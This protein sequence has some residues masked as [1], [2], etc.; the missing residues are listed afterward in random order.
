M[1]YFVGL[2]ACF[3]YSVS[4]ESF[5]NPGLYLDGTFNSSMFFHCTSAPIWIDNEGM[6]NISGPDKM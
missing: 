1:K 2:G 3:A 5:E 6:C 4:S